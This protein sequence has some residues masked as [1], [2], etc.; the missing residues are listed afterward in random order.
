MLRRYLVATDHGDVV[1]EVNEVA[2]GL[3]PGLFTLLAPSDVAGADPEMAVPLRAFGAKVVDLVELMGVGDL[4]GGEHLKRMMIRE[5]ATEELRRI[6][7]WTRER[8]AAGG[9]A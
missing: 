9:E 6:E 7:R 2:S 4:P 1:V 5:R 8:A 3:D